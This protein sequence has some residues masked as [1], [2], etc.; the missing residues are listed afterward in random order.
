MELLIPILLVPLL[1]LGVLIL[2]WHFRRSNSLLQEWARRNGL[3][4]LRQDFRFL[5]RGPF[6]LTTS[7]HQTVYHVTVE[8]QQGNQRHCW[9]RCGSWF[10]GLFSDKVEA[11]WED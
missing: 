4:V 5:F 3:R 7:Q 2:L 6:F 9:V 8:D 10:L 11:R 1:G